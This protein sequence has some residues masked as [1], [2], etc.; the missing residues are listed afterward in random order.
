MTKDDITASIAWMMARPVNTENGKVDDCM[1]YQFT[2]PEAI[3]KR[4]MA[5][6]V[7]YT[8]RGISDTEHYIW[9]DLQNQ[10]YLWKAMKDVPDGSVEHVGYVARDLFNDL[11]KEFAAKHLDKFMQY[12]SIVMPLEIRSQAKGRDLVELIEHEQKWIEES[13]ADKTPKGHLPEWVYVMPEIMKEDFNAL[14][15]ENA[16]K[17]FRHSHVT[18]RAKAYATAALKKIE[19]RTAEVGEDIKSKLAADILQASMHEA[20]LVWRKRLGVAMEQASKTICHPPPKEPKKVESR[21]SK[22]SIER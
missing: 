14:L 4:F 6:A 20:C 11:A 17:A 9:S 1:K 18:D 5:F 16:E 3:K 12:H 7:E 8:K 15:K 21:Y 13:L 2:P 19:D 10:A 22:Q